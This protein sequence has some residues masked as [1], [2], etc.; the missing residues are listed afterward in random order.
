MDWLDIILDHV[1]EYKLENITKVE[2]EYLHHYNT[3]RL[4]LF[5]DTLNERV[6][7]YQDAID[8]TNQN[9]ESKLE[10][11]WGVILNDDFETFSKIY[12]VP[13]MVLFSKWWD[14]EVKY[15]NKF[16]EYWES[17]YEIKL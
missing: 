16:E 8:D 11:L 13:H 10:I 12:K 7:Y 2:Q 6:S 15:R 1:S 14:V 17:Y 5:E 4:S 9:R 3:D